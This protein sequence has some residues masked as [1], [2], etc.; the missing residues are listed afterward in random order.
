MTP[1]DARRR[2]EMPRGAQRRLDAQ[3][4]QATRLETSRNARGRQK[5][6]DARRLPET[7]RSVRRRQSTRGDAQ[8][9][10]ETLWHA[11]RHQET[12]RCLETPEVVRRRQGHASVFG[13][14]LRSN[15]QSLVVTFQ[16]RLDQSSPCCDVVPPAPL[17]CHPH[18]VM[19]FLCQGLFGSCSDALALLVTLRRMLRCVP[20]FNALPVL[21]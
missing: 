18:A 16:L 11:W 1:R 6:R 17:T 7:Q 19:L 10:Q 15:A 2:K 20:K 4:R 21:C 13:G 12:K 3:R 9:R 14:C 5:P 8:R